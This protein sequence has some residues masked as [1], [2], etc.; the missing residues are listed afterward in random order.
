MTTLY[1]CTADSKVDRCAGPVQD[2]S[3]TSSCSTSIEN[4]DPFPDW[5]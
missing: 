1:A 4:T 2:T 3:F 5:G